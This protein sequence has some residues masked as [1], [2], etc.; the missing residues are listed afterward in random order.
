MIIKNLLLKWQLSS[1]TLS[2]ISIVIIICEYIFHLIVQIWELYELWLSWNLVLLFSQY[3]Y[4][5]LCALKAVAFFYGQLWFGLLNYR[6]SSRFSQEKRSEEGMKRSFFIDLSCIFAHGIWYNFL[7]KNK[8][9]PSS[10]I[11]PLKS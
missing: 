3:I 10:Q 4:W 6:A 5:L 11:L 7:C 8:Q 1:M 9:S 2:L